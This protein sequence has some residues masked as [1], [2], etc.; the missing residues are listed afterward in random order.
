MNSVERI[1]LKLTLI[2][3][4][5]LGIA[6]CGGSGGAD[7]PGGG[8]KPVTPAGK[9]IV[10]PQVE[11]NMSLIPGEERNIRAKDASAAKTTDVLV[12]KGSKTFECTITKVSNT[13]FKFRVPSDLVDGTYKLIIT[14]GNEISQELF[15]SK[16]TC[17]ATNMYVADKPA[18]ERYTLKGKVYCGSK[19]VEGVLVTDGVTFTQ[20]NADGH[21]WLKS[22]KRYQMVYLVLPSGYEVPTNAALP[23]FWAMTTTELNY[24]SQEQHN[25][26]LIK[27]DNTNHRV[28]VVTDI[29]LANRKRKPLDLNQFEEGFVKEVVTEYTGRSNVYCLNLGDFAWDAY[30]YNNSY[31]ITNAAAQISRLPVQFW[32]TM[33]NHDNDG[34]TTAGEDVDL[35]ASLPYR[36]VLGPT[37]VAF[38]FGK[39]HYILIDDILYKNT[40][41]SSTA[42]P[43]LGQRDYSCG[44]RAD[45]IEWV[46]Q[47]LSYVDKNTP[48]VVGLHS[49]LCYWTGAYNSGEFERSNWKAFVDLFNDYKEVQFIS[50][51][52]HVNRMHNINGYGTNLYE[53][54]IGALSGVWWGTSEVTG[55]TTTKVGALNLCSDGTP[56]GYMVMDAEG[57]S[58]TWFYK[59]VHEADNKQFKS[60]D[61][62]EVRSFF[63]SYGPA[64]KFITTGSCKNDS[65]SGSPTNTWTKKEYGC[66]EA[67]NTVW[68][69]VWNYEKGSFAGY[70]NWEI[71]V[72][73]NGQQLQVEEIFSGYHD[74]LS[75]LFEIENFTLT[76]SFPSTQSSRNQVPHLFRV[77]ASSAKSTLII[78][79]KD[80][81]GNVYR[82]NME[83]PKK[84]YNGD[85]TATWTLD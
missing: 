21:Y 44:F 20:T 80:R 8:D 84:F 1:I 73:E 11:A 64:N 45:M 10:D 4:V 17:Q 53:N 54:N 60:Y 23:K 39:V 24:E 71:T 58:R 38:N 37:Y 70:G 40:F 66:E 46:K 61:M 29:H 26:E 83:R 85:I 72:T 18:S 69:N 16:I 75:A 78:S 55:G 33:G 63:N 14:R 57:A 49:P 81:H 51:H 32:S 47:N 34:R 41:P 13:Y 52:T 67:D 42:D 79:V 15:T 65:S 82:E 12:L 28:L 74:P 6:A 50:G 5:M 3:A 76:G 56:S 7:E 22:D 19:G 35:R 2:V 43:L 77:V 31:D 36:K 62:N 30:W 59:G 9:I 25:F 48:I 68:I 27:K